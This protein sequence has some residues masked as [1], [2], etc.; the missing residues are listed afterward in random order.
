[1]NLFPQSLLSLAQDVIERA[2]EK[3]AT[4]AV[5]ESCTGGLVSACITAVP[6]SS[7]VLDAGFVTYSNS[8]KEQTLGVPSAT[9]AKFGAVSNETAM[10]MAM[11]ACKASARA[12]LAV[13]T[14]G[15]AGPGGG[16]ED[17]PA[18]LVYIGFYGDADQ[19][20]YAMAY[21]FDGDRHEVR[22]QAV[23]AALSILK[24]ELENL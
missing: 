11:G 6:G 9:L 13:S 15:I 19:K 4:I 10:E 23:E 21:R 22:I 14:T 8:A 18:G 20:I 7:D 3:N 2:R 16:S 24:D 12:T 1:M 5:A 17:K